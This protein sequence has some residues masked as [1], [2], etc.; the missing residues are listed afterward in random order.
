[1]KSGDNFQMLYTLA[2]KLG[3]AVG[4]YYFCNALKPINMRWIK[5]GSQLY[6]KIRHLGTKKWLIL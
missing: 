1:M 4:K 6:L 5:T 3:A 2:D